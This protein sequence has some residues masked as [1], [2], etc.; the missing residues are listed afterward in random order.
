I[1]DLENIP[2]LSLKNAGKLDETSS[3]TDLTRESVKTFVMSY[4]AVPFKT[5]LLD[6][7]FG[8]FI[9]SLNMS[10]YLLIAAYVL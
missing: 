2:E 8:I 1:F 9:F 3:L 4:L 5:R 10:L 7:D 6:T